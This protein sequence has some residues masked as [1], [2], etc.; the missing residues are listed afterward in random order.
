MN[1]KSLYQIEGIQQEEEDIIAQLLAPNITN[2]WLG[3]EV[4][5]ATTIKLSK[6]NTDFPLL[7]N[8]PRQLSWYATFEWHNYSS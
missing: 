6:T 5:A 8:W 2:T 3:N 1:A 4:F 7:A